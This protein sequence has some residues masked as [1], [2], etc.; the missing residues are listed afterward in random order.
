[1]FTSLFIL[2]SEIFKNIS[3]MFF[4]EFVNAQ[5]TADT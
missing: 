2:I 5:Q 1:M 3:K 4:T